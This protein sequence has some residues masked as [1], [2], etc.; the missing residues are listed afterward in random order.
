[1][2]KIVKLMAKYYMTSPSETKFER[3]E[4]RRR[5]EQEEEDVRGQMKKKGEQRHN[6]LAITLH[7]LKAFWGE[8]V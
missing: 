1:M 4:T 3:K 7:S 2:I 8:D 6:A 5:E